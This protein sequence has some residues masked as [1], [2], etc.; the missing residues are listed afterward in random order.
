MAQ[1][2]TDLEEL[3][4]ELSIQKVSSFGFTY[5]C[6]GSLLPEHSYTCLRLA[7]KC[8]KTISV[9]AVPIT[10]RDKPYEEILSLVAKDIQYYTTDYLYLPKDVLKYKT[11][12]FNAYNMQMIVN[13]T[14]TAMDGCAAGMAR[15]D[16][17]L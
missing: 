7:E 10:Y 1:L 11:G 14:V 2:F 3:K 17:G 12:L 4:Q 8:D 15:L 6:I 5:F 13:G 16:K 9:F